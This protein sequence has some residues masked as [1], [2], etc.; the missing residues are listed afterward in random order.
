MY[1]SKNRRVYIQSLV[2]LLMLTMGCS[3][4]SEF[5][6]DRSSDINLTFEKVDEFSIGG[7]DV[8]L[9]RVRNLVAAN[10]DGS[11]L[12]WINDDKNE[13]ILTDSR[14]NLVSKFGKKG[15]GSEEFSNIAAFG[16]DRNNRF[17]VYD[18]SQDFFKKFSVDGELLWI[19]KGLLKDGLWTRSNR[20]ISYNNHMYLGIQ[21][22]GVDIDWKSRTVAM[23]N[24]D[25][26]FSSLFGAY[27][28]DLRGGKNRELY[29][30]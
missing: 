29:V 15:R 20:I 5:S 30:Y 11:L 19:E 26:Q 8:T 3:N 16:F 18:S 4:D 24:D 1:K 9:D 13:I 27:D 2:I 12:A 17:I 25:G 7:Q 28:P 6:N 14:G 23:Y 10:R 22:S 21:E